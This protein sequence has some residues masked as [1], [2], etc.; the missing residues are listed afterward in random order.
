MHRQRLQADIQAY[1]K[2]RQ[3]HKRLFL[4]A[5]CWPFGR[6]YFPS[7][8]QSLMKQGCT[9]T[10]FQNSTSQRFDWSFDGVGGAV[11]ML[12]REAPSRPRKLLGS[13]NTHCG[14]SKHPSMPSWLTEGHWRQ[15]RDVVQ[16]GLCVCVCL[17]MHAFKC[18]F[19][20]VCVRV[21]EHCVCV[22][23]HLNVCLWAC[24]VC[25]GQFLS[26][27]AIRTCSDV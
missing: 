3:M 5:F 27:Q 7:W 13:V 19:V 2:D 17:C 4:E 22:C 23:M 11:H 16:G 26:F 10:W 8:S 12:G 21:W 6:H 14:E 15:P 1:L 24:V 9:L 20:S 18:V 25:G